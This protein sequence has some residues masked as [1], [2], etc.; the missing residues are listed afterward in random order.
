MNILDALSLAS[1]PH[2][3][4]SRAMYRQ[5]PQTGPALNS[6]YVIGDETATALSKALSLEECPLLFVSATGHVLVLRLGNSGLVAIEAVDTPTDPQ[7][8]V[9][10]EIGKASYDF[11]RV[12]FKDFHEVPSGSR[13]KVKPDPV[14]VVEPE[15]LVSEPVADEVDSSEPTE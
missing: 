6:V 4:D 3:V 10:S 11:D 14:P 9:L 15:D 2:T 8:A 5:I 12:P 7:T 1:I 13:K